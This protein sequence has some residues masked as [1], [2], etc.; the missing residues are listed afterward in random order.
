MVN[1]QEGSAVVRNSNDVM[2]VL[3]LAPPMAGAGG[4]QRYTQALV[5]ALKH[6]LG[7]ENVRCLA[8][9]VAPDGSGRGRFLARSKLTFGCHALWEAVRWRPDLAI[10]T[11]LALGPLG[12]SVASIGHCPYW[13]VLHGIEAWYVLEGWKRRALHRAD[14]FIVTSTFS[15]EQVVNRHRID[16]KRISSLPCTLD[17]TLL[18]TKPAEAGAAARIAKGQRLVLT[19]ARMAAWERYKGHDIVLQALPQVVAR[20]PNLTYV[21]VGDGD[22]R[23]RLEGM[24]REMGLS[25]NVVFTGEVTDSELAAL[26]Q[27]SEAFVLPAR[28]VIDEHNPKGEG[29][30]IVFLEAMAFGKPVIGPNYGAPAELIQNGKFGFLVDPE[31]PAA[32]AG[33]MLRLLNAPRES[34]NLGESASRWVREE[35]S[36]N[37]LCRRLKGLLIES[38]Y[39]D[40]IR[41]DPAGV[42]ES[43]GASRGGSPGG[44][45]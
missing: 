26:Y 2:K 34:R 40:R 23:P 42:L 27:R 32:V 6:I 9:P 25:A 28:T 16:E 20:I 4:I 30:G 19:V 15:R 39:V 36:F 1:E 41:Q 7:E 43:I 13:I 24:V 11:H 44:Q 35:Y 37:S 18:S 10:C 14:R 21:M 8:I 12:W 45:A 29:F 5:Q 33:G 3:V 38:G 22:D 17:E 31:D